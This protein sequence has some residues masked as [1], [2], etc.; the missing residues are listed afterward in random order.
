MAPKPAKTAADY[1]AIAVCPAL[2]MVLVGSLVFFLVQ[3]GFAGERIGLI[4][5]TLFWFVFAMVL[6]SRIAI[7]QSAGA[8][9]L[10]GLALALATSTM[11]SRYIGFMWGVWLLLALIW[12]AS[13]KIVWDCTF[14]DDDQDASGQGLLQISRLDLWR[15]A[16]LAKVKAVP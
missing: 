4:R 6:V 16:Q 14:I 12:W 2:I 13:N 15:R 1:M 10:Y 8:A 3:I 5:W 11:L 9:F 7:Q